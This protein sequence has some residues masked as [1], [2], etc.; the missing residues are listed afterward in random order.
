ME[1]RTLSTRATR[2]DARAKASTLLA[3][4]EEIRRDTE[5]LAARVHREHQALPGSSARRAVAMRLAAIAS[6]D[7]LKASQTLR[8]ITLPS[9]DGTAASSRSAL[10]LETATQE[11]KA[12][13]KLAL[14]AQALATAQAKE[15]LRGTEKEL[16]DVVTRSALKDNALRTPEE[17]AKEARLY[18][19]ATLHAAATLSARPDAD[20]LKAPLLELLRAA[21]A[22]FTEAIGLV[23]TK[24]PGAAQTALRNGIGRLEEAIALSRKLRGELES[25]LARAEEILE[26]HEDSAT[27]NGEESEVA[28]EL[29]AIYAELEKIRAMRA[30][31][32]DIAARLEA[33][34]HEGR[35]DAERREEIAKMQ[36]KLAERLEGN[37]LSVAE[38][39]ELVSKL[40]L[41]DRSAR[42]IAALERTLAAETEKQLRLD[43]A[44]NRG[45]LLRKQK[46][47]REHAERMA[48]AF[49]ASGHKLSALLPQVL[50]AYW[51]A[52]GALDLV[53]KAM[54]DA[55]RALPAGNEPQNK[56]LGAARRMDAFLT[57]VRALRSV[58]GHRPAR[59]RAAW[60][61]RAR[62]SKRRQRPSA[63][64]TR[65]ELPR[66]RA[67]LAGR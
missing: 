22:L 28:P 61:A 31:E 27:D 64:G 67:H 15:A 34:L 26:D 50:E 9:S 37:V 13:E 5:G 33:L 19:D 7:M 51:N 49:Q 40:V 46:D 47:A 41:I 65:V 53:L 25:D 16:Q 10:L 58:A 59:H 52:G 29:A 12:A 8:S 35:L 30:L 60:L 1:V 11:E 32:Q 43:G 54:E 45:G 62:A 17:I 36:E 63:K 24:E 39:V 23:E 18:L 20:L 4:H 6:G 38:L 48:E 3:A 57:R 14:I 42:E 21:S 55:E 56:I 66:H 44:S 2:P